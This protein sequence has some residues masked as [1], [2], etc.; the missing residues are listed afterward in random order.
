MACWK[1]RTEEAE[2]PRWLA[3]DTVEEVEAS[4]SAADRGRRGRR[5]GRWRGAQKR[6]EAGGSKAE[7]AV[8]SGVCR[9]AAVGE[10]RGGGGAI[11]KVGSACQVEVEEDKGGG[12]GQA[13][14]AAEAGKKKM[15]RGG[16]IRLPSSEDVLQLHSLWR[17]NDKKKKKKPPVCWL[18]IENEDRS[19]FFSWRCKRD[20]FPL[21]RY[22]R[23]G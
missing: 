1:V 21:H 11:I 13:V 15:V 9:E 17:I 8:S 22:T 6:M 19:F 23:I 20:F 14:A 4:P 7:G 3:A 2:E 10:R 12:D 18:E 16:W 5:H